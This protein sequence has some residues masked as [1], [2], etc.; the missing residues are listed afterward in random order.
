MQQ[1]RVSYMFPTHSLALGNVLLCRAHHLSKSCSD[2][3]EREPLGDD[4]PLFP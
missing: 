1:D 2:T 4:K 3:E